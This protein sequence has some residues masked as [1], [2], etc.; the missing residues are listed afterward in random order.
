MPFTING[1]Q[2]QDLGVSTMEAESSISGVDLAFD[3]SS[4]GPGGGTFTPVRLEDE[5]GGNQGI[6]M[7][8]TDGSYRFGGLTPGSYRVVRGSYRSELLVLGAGQDL[9]HDLPQE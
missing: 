6:A 7:P 4:F 9:L 3:P 1:R 8:Q 5:E 2:D